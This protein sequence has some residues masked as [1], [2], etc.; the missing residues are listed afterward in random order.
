MASAAGP[1][2]DPVA[3]DFEGGD[4]TCLIFQPFGPAMAHRFFVKISFCQLYK[5]VIVTGLTFHKAPVELSE[6]TIFETFA[7]PFEAFAAT[8]FYERKDQ[9]PVEKAFFF[10]AAFALK[11]HQ[12]IYILVFALA[13]E[14]EPSFLQF[15]QYEA[16]VAPFFGDDRR[17]VVDEALARGV[18]GD[19][20]DAAGGGFLLAPGVVGEDVF[21]G[22]GREVDPPWV[23]R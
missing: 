18:P 19:E 10:A 12:F 15:G 9:E 14:L 23:G 2:M 16:E 20:G 5:K 7:K 17:E 22:D 4:D 3:A 11:F 8:G 6:V 13:S 21:E 1:L